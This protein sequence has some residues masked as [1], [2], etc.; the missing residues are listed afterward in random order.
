MPWSLFIRVKRYWYPLTRKMVNWSFWR[1][2]PSP[3]RESYRR[4]SS[5]QHS[6]YTDNAP[7][8]IY[9]TYCVSTGSVLCHSTQINFWWTTTPHPLFK[10][11]KENHLFRT[12]IFSNQV[13]IPDHMFTLLEI[14]PLIFTAHIYF[15]SVDFCRGKKCQNTAHMNVLLGKSS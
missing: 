6:H 4:L 10:E 14:I 2:T 8:L 11:P 13:A 15:T 5:S 1:Q 3:C 12:V 9:S 7:P